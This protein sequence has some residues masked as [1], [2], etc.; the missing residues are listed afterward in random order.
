VTRAFGALLINSGNPEG[1]SLSF[2]GEG[3]LVTIGETSMK[4]HTRREFLG[5]TI[6]GAIGAGAALSGLSD[7][8]LFAQ[9]KP[10]IA[11]PKPA[12]P[13][14]AS[15]LAAP[16]RAVAAGR[17]GVLLD[18]AMAGWVLSAEGSHAT[19]DA[20]TQKG[21]AAELERKHIAGVKYEDI[22][23]QCGTGMSK[24]FY[25]WIKA[26][27]D[28]KHVRKD[29]AIHSCDYDGNIVSTLEFFHALITEVGFPALD[30]ASKD[31]AKLSIKISPETTR[32]VE[33][34]AG[35]LE[36]PGAA[37]RTV[38]Q[39]AWLPANF[40]LQ[41]AGLDCT[42]VNKIEA[43]TIK[44]KIVDNAVGE[45]R[46]ISKEPAK[47]EIPNLVITLPE[48]H[49]A[50][51]A[52]WHKE[53]LVAGNRGAASRKSGQLEYLASDLHD[54]LFTLDFHGLGIFKMT[55]DKPEAGSENIRRVKCEL[56][57]EKIDF[58]Y[59]EGSTWA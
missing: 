51:F 9:T 28:N 1:G 23:L 55:P 53:S 32:M 54:P 31:S 15:P 41:I 44:Q 4:K 58:K 18:G 29:G 36:I 26:S 33:K 52:A 7:N 20:V 8:A 24:P 42:H 35:K 47:L 11:N 21:A 25:E 5:K 34:R 19:S 38:R 16:S 13:Q 40:R 27:F 49:A 57:C 56:Y 46:S 22:T 2:A 45:M 30:A 6:V 14:T 50:A 39:K 37:Q 17:Y 48:Q 59:G 12:S 3:L 10:Q 43:I